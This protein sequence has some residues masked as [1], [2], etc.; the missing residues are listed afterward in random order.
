[1]TPIDLLILALAAYLLTDYLVNRELPY[2]IMGRIRD[3]L[4][5]GTLRC[6]YCASIWCGIAVY[7]L[8]LVEPQLIY[9][10]AIGGGAVLM[11][12]YTGASHV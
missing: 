9:P 6:F 1:M 7:L 3:R 10:F 12:R 4:Q 5:W 2:N 8:W 11:W